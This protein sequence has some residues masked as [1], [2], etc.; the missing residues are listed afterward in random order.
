MS[1]NETP[2]V[3]ADWRDAAMNDALAA[4]AARGKAEESLLR[5]LRQHLPG[6]ATINVYP[7]RFQLVR[8][9]QENT[10]DLRSLLS[11]S[12]A[13]ESSNE[14]D[15]FWPYLGWFGA[16]WQGVEIEVVLAPDYNK[17]AEH[18]C[19]CRDAAVLKAFAQ[20]VVDAGDRP[21]GR[22]LRYTEGWESAPDLD[23][24]IGKVTWDDIVLPPDTLARLREAVEG[25]AGQKDAY[26]AM[27]FAWR[28]G[29]LLIGPPGTGKTMVCKAA[30]AALPDLPFLY[31]RDLRED[32]HKE[33]IQAIFR[34]ARKLAP[35]VLALEDMD[36]LITEANR[37]LFL[38]E[39]DGFHDNDGILLI[40][41]SNHPGKIDEALLKRPSRFDRVF[42]LGL[43][44]LAER[45]TF[46]E[47]V[48]GRPSLA[49]R[50][51]PDLDAATLAGEVAEKT[52]GFTP[53]YLKEVFIAA[54]LERAQAG[55]A[56]LDLAFAQA[57]LSQV[58]ELKK[59]GRRLRDPEALAELRTG[60]GTIGLRRNRI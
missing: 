13:Y 29:V 32:D 11:G 27:G 52:D 1:N 44:A 8:F 55:A 43:P 57:V 35:C 59:L 58:D 53:A 39:L 33:A 34:R 25:W 4:K 18:I 46:C 22:S 21:A 36:G 16:T 49:S 47:R 12:H 19:V 26:A 20:A 41:S 5:S 37:A 54:A 28:R 7:D 42:H 10:T 2:P 50:M 17:H 38:N 51:A 40:A 14:T 3:P 45:R 48:L 15:V 31:V 6:H 23:E 30:A 60:E 24:E 56:L 9:L